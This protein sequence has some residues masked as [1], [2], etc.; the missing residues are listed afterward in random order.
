MAN[1][2][3]IIRLTLLHTSQGTDL[4][5]WERNQCR[6]EENVFV[7]S[8]AGCGRVEDAAWRAEPHLGESQANKASV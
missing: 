4:R 3:S 7:W 6:H 1:A 2:R 8:R 5:Q